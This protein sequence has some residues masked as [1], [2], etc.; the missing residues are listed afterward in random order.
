MKITLQSLIIDC[1]QEQAKSTRQIVNDIASNG[2]RKATVNT[3]SC[4]LN[5][6]VE[7]GLISRFGADKNNFKY[8]ANK[9]DFGHGTVADINRLLAKVRGNK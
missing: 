1:V 2:Q 4:Q 9:K 3:V 5:K 7:R 6:L 8:M